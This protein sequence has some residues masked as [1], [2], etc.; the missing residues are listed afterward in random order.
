MTF[1]KGRSNLPSGGSLAGLKDIV[2]NGWPYPFR[3]PFGSAWAVWPSDYAT[4]QRFFPWHLKLRSIDW[5]PGFSAQQDGPK[6]QGRPVNGRFT[7]R[8]ITK[9]QTS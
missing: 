9:A 6:T 4:A 7:L 5:P 2:L 3:R 8:A 1:Q